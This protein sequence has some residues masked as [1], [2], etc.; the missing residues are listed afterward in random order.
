MSRG[1]GVVAIIVGLLTPHVEKDS[2][3][4]GNYSQRAFLLCALQT[5]VGVHSRDDSTGNEG[6]KLEPLSIG[7]RATR[8]RDGQA[9]GLAHD[10]HDFLE[11]DPFSKP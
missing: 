4:G 2:A 3:V 8:D 7:V 10:P 9:L 11:V 1:N 6:R 5:T